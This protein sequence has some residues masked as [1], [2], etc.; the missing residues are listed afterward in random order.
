MTVDATT[1][2]PEGLERTITASIS[3]PATATPNPVPKTLKRRNGETEV[4]AGTAFR[5]GA[6]EV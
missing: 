2:E 6:G 1:T 5:G 4:E 3:S